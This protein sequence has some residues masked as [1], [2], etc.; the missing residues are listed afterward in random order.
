MENQDGKRVAR[1]PGMPRGGKIALAVVLVL[2]LALAGGYVGLCAYAGSSAFLPNTSIAG[3]DVSGQSR[4]GAAAALGGA[5]PGLLADSRAEFT[6]AGQSY[7]VNGDDPSVSVD[8]A[9]A[10]DAALTDQAGSFFTRGGRYLAAVMHGNRYSVPVTLT[11]TPDAVTRAVEE[12]SDPE[13][14]TTWEVTD[15][16]LVLHKGVTGR[17]IDVAALTDALAERLGHLISDDIPVGYGPIETQVTTAPPAAPDFDAIRSEV[18]AEPA[19]AYLDKET[20]EIVPSVTGVDFDTAQ[21]QAVLDAAGEGE[22]VSVPLLLTE[23]E[24]TTAKLE[25]NLFKDVLGSGS[26]TCAGPSNRWYN[27]DLAAKRLNGTILLPGETFSYNDTVGPYTLASGY[28][29]AG[30]YQNGQSV[31]AT[32]GGICQLSSNLYW[33]TLKANLEIVE[34]H[35]HQFNG[36][37]MPV[38]GTDAT[39]WSDQLDFRFQNNTDYPIKIESYLDKNHKLHVTIYGTDTTGIHG[40]PYHVVISTVPYKNTYQPKDS[41][42]VGTE[43]QRDPNYSRYNGYTVDL[44]QKLVD[45]NGKTISTTLLYRNTYKASDAVYYYNPADAARWGIDPSTGLKTLTPVTPTPSPSPSPSPAPSPTPGGTPSPVPT[46]TPV[47]PLEPSPTV[48]PSPES[49]PAYTPP[50]EATATPESG[51][52][53]GMEPVEE[54]PAVTP[55]TGSTPAAVPSA[56][57]A[58]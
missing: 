34:R 10:V 42:P 33:V 4:E 51:V 7:A 45:K 40:E 13:A 56:A 8:A 49:P 58:A 19:D 55:E 32:A 11:G 24:L 38:I 16:E 23:P 3:V 57:P 18:A 43:P 41:I 48:P 25:A 9:A 22:T 31:D 30:T 2:V 50:V 29:A 26:T 14:Q 37:Y 12:C 1:G 17:T 27:I 47:L 39:V 5:L 20:R 21:A 53:P 36:G 35:K 54:T 46:A 44:Y 6:C 52:G 15:T 28:K